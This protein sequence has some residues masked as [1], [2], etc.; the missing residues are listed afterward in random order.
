[1]LKQNTK[2]LKNNFISKW[3]HGFMVGD[4]AVINRHE[5]K[6]VHRHSFS[7]NLTT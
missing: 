5:S 3:N 7:Y 6:P 1:V 2:I 4:K